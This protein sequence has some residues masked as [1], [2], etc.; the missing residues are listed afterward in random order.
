MLQFILLSK[1]VL[2]GLTSGARSC[3]W[4]AYEYTIQRIKLGNEVLGTP[5]HH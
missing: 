3:S 5:K 1:D 4:W 2:A